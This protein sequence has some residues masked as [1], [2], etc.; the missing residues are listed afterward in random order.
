MDKFFKIVKVEEPKQKKKIEYDFIYNNFEPNNFDELKINKN[1]GIKLNSVIEQNDILNLFIHGRKGS[2]KA[3]LAKLYIKKYLGIDYIL[4]KSTFTS[5][6]KEFVYFKN[7]YI[8]ELV[9]NS[10]NFNDIN[11]ISELF[12]TICKKE[13]GGFSDKK[14][15]I[16]IRNIH[17]VKKMFH[18]II[19]NN[20]DKY[21]SF[22]TFVFIS[23][24]SIPNIFRGF[25]CLIR[26][27]LPSNKE[28][29][30]LGREIKPDSKKSELEYIIK[31][32]DNSLVKFKNILNL[33]Y[34]DNKYEKYEDSDK[35]KLKFLHKILYK[36]KIITLTI[37]RD[38]INELFIDNVNE[39][40]IIMYLLNGFQKDSLKEKITQEKNKK[41]RDILIET[42]E[43]LS[44]GFRPIHHLEYAFIRIINLL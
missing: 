26:V 16:I 6:S 25:F 43:N 17:L 34:I 3:L 28:L 7:N 23:Q 30:T 10:Q 41:I 36:K 8:C 19:K 39:G 5:D 15:I 1:I 37:L 27:P 40:V 44:R 12:K 24:E 13:E 42:D 18:T 32:S 4:N 2:G 33:S 31:I 21:S 9:I 29:F 14:K 35:D 38:L 11:L 20:I 22:N